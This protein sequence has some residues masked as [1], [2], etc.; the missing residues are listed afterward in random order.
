MKQLISIFSIL[1]LLL[2]SCNNTKKVENTNDI[3]DSIENSG[4]IVNT[5]NVTLISSAKKDLDNWKEYKNLDDFL[6]KYYNISYF[7]ALDNAKELSGLVKSLKDSLSVEKLNKKNVVARINVLENE[8]L[9]LADMATIS[10]I[11]N[12]EVKTE[13]DK[14]VELFDALNSKINTIYKTEELQ[15]S[16]E[17][18]TETPIDI[19]E[20]KGV[21]YIKRAPIKPKSIPKKNKIIDNEKV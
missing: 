5:I 3:K 6:I 1:F 16:L 8:A 2:A 20:E 14:I 11:T 10:S 9:R 18:D 7:D 15:K 4:R 12:Q 19:D 13:V 21:N 17:I